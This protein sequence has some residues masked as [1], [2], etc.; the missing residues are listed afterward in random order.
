MDLV[1]DANIFI[2]A[3]IKDGITSSLI[4]DENLHL[5]A[6]EFILE[7]YQKYESEILQKT[8][9]TLEDF[10]QFLEIL[11]RRISFISRESVDTFLH[12]AKEFTLDPKDVVY[13]AVALKIGAKVWSNDKRLKKQE[14]VEVLT[15]KDI[16]KLFN[17]SEEF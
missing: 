5:F 11:N 7:E 8:H 1:L 2:A 3:L 9:R 14:I 13:I 17:P 15:T 10:Q 12:R 4:V 6:P 16:V